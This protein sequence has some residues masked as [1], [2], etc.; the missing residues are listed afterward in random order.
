[1]WWLPDPKVCAARTRPV[2]NF[3][4]KTWGSGEE[5]TDNSRHGQLS[6][7]QFGHGFTWTFYGSDAADKMPSLLII[8]GPG[9]ASEG[10]ADAVIP[11]IMGD[12]QYFST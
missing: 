9:F 6:G 2:P 11:S 10:R 4:A 7:L 12:R 1:M 8:L 3:D 5:M